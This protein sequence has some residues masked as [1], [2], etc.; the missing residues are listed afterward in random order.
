MKRSVWRIKEILAQLWEGLA[1]EIIEEDE[2]QL[3]TKLQLI[4]DL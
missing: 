1:V 3:P 2:E 4:E